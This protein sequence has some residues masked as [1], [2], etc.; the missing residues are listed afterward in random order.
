[1]NLKH[2]IKVNIREPDTNGKKTIL[3]VDVKPV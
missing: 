3:F 1:M 2:R